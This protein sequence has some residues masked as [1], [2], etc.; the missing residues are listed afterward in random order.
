MNLISGDAYGIVAS[1]RRPRMDLNLEYAAHQKAL[2]S[3]TDATSD[4]D[5]IAHLSQAIVIA[6][7]IG[8]FQKGLGA[9]A[10]SAWCISQ[11]ASTASA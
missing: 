4:A 3:A 6:D 10:A 1:G 8:S 7:R 5:R 2:M 9:A 11:H